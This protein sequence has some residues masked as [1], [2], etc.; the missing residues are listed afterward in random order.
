M[1]KD[2]R[3]LAQPLVAAFVYTVVVEDHVVFRYIVR[4]QFLQQVIHKREE[5]HALF[6]FVVLP[7]MTPVATS[8]A[9]NRF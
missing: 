7:C 9:A 6:A 5:V 2:V 3:M 8:S 1:E 4:G